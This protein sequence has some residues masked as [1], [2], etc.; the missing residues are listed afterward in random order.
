MALSHCSHF[1]SENASEVWLLVNLAISPEVEKLGEIKSP[2]GF[3]AGSDLLQFFL[4]KKA[5]GAA[6]TPLILCCTKSTLLNKI[7]PL[8]HSSGIHRHF[9]TGRQGEA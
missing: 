9:L 4:D 6:E 7:N 3:A 2:A 8:V 5:L 1:V